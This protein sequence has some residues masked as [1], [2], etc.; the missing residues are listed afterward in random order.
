MQI[1]MQIENAVC[2]FNLINT[3][4]ATHYPYFVLFWLC[5]MQQRRKLHYND[6]ENCYYFHLTKILTVSYVNKLKGFFPERTNKNV[7]A[8]KM[9]NNN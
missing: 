2:V 6:M 4:F 9:E 7:L 3:P 1:L 8:W 5:C